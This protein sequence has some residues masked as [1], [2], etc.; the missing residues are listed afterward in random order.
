[1]YRARLPWLCAR[2]WSR[3]AAEPLDAASVRIQV[4]DGAGQSSK[5]SNQGV[6]ATLG[7]GFA[8]A[9]ATASVSLADA[10]GAK[11][12]ALDAA[13]P[14]ANDLKGA[15]KSVT[16]GGVTITVQG[17]ASVSY[18][19]LVVFVLGGPG[20]G[21]GT[22]CA[23]LVEEFDMAH[24]SAGDLLREHCKSGTPD[25]NMVADAIKN[26]LIVPAEV[27]IRLLEK[28][29]ADSGKQKI[30]IDGFP[31][32]YDNREAFQRVIGYDCDL[33]LY[34]DCPESVLESLLMK[35][36]QSSDHP[37][38]SKSLSKPASSC[39]LTQPAAYVSKV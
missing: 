37:H 2:A 27:T 23:K 5:G 32:N 21:K 20:S 22:Q 24:F 4:L 16:V 29:M 10:A 9:Y 36:G 12:Q 31:R 6:W 3:L 15:Q 19:H 34:F 11:G 1:M 17:N 13:P 25:G 8:A 33:V 38:G 7:L 26:G 18:K 14:V 30:L 35:R 39:Q 28:A